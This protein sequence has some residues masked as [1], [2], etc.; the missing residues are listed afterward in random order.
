[1]LNDSSNMKTI[2]VMTLIFLPVSTVAAVFGSQFFATTTE[3]EWSNSR[4]RVHPIMWIF[5][6]I[7]VPLTVAVYGDGGYGLFGCERGF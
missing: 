4:F 7:S 1:M 6:A 5:C 2:A 3:D